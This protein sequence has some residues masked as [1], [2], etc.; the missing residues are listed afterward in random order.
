MGFITVTIVNIKPENILIWSDIWKLNMNHLE[1][2]T[3]NI[4]EHTLQQET[5]LGF[6]LVENTETYWIVKLFT[7]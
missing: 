4:V 3:V 6:I 1:D 7:S 2:T 5:L